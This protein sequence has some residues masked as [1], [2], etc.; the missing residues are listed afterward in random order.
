MKM[1][2]K[3]VQLIVDA[4]K[5]SKDLYFGQEFGIRPGD[6]IRTAYETLRHPEGIDYIIQDKAQVRMHQ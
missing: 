5:T 3:N 4:E 2:N 6:E 1:Y